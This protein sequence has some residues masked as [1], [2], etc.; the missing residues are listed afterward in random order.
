YFL[1]YNIWF[2]A[3]ALITAEAQ[4]TLEY[5]EVGAKLILQPKPFSG[6]IKSITW[7]FND[8]IVGVLDEGQSL[9]YSTAFRDRASVDTTTGVLEISNMTKTDSGLYKVTINNKI[10]DG[11]Y[12]VGVIKQVP[13][14]ELKITPSTCSNESKSC[15]LS[16]DGDITEAGP[17]TFYFYF[18]KGDGVWKEREENITIMND[19]DTQAVGNFSC[20]MKN[21]FG[22]KDSGLVNNPFYVPP[23]PVPI[24]PTV[25]IVLGVLAGLGVIGGVGGGVYYTKN[26]SKNDRPSASPNYNANDSDGRPLNGMHSDSKEDP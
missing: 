8:N 21:P 24:P 1:K 22:Q 5:L 16:C 20:R 15:L 9:R 19:N 14:P 18:Q 13:K 25:G 4:N 23:K 3:V 17:V 10:Q 6:P 7:R 11:G 26:K 2:T 12:D